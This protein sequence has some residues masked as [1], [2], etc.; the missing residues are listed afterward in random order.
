L[1]SSGVRLTKS[2]LNGART[3]S[4]VAVHD[5]TGAAHYVLDVHWSL[6][7][8]ELPRSAGHLHLGSFPMFLGPCVAAVEELLRRTHELMTTSLDPNV[9]ADLLPSVGE[10]RE[11]LEGL[12]CSTDV[13]KASDE[14]LLW[15]YPRV[16]P[17]RVADRWLNLGATLVVVTSGSRGA[18]AQTR[19]G[20][21]DVSA[22]KVDVVDTV[23]AGDSFM[24]ALLD[25]LAG[26][27][28]LGVGRAGA[29]GATDLD[30]LRAVLGRS[31]AAAA[32]TVGRAGASPPTA[33]E[34]GERRRF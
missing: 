14:D 20:R 33:S 30:L 19:S 15:M 18:F 25:G 13:V 23:G 12:L 16:P 31:V 2:A 6:E 26:A 28:L 3:P 10:V 34:L 17:H 4:A 21:F 11:R 32:I 9:R 27:G 24:A 7:T 5:D 1:V 29:L 8:S 22:P